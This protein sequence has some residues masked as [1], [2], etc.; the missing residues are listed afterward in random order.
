[1][2]IKKNTD[3]SLF[4]DEETIKRNNGQDLSEKELA[5]EKAKKNYN[6][7][8]VEIKTLK[9]FRRLS[10]QSPKALKLLFTLAEKM[11]RMNAIMASNATLSQIAG[12]SIP[13]VTRAIKLL[14]EERWIQVVRIGT[15]NAYVINS[16]V[17]WKSTG[18]LKHASFHAQII[19]SSDEQTEPVE[20]WDGV[21]LKHFPF[22]GF[23]PDADITLAPDPRQMDLLENQEKK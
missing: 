18:D 23:N 6:F 22:M 10:D 16:T 3:K 9:E 8:Q 14:K 17:F 13:T 20:N 19:A 4:V 7:L 1:M 15:A 21:T 5:D 11:N 12:M 2:N